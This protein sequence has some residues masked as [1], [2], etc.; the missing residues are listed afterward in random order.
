MQSHRTHLEK[1]APPLSRGFP[2]KQGKGYQPGQPH[3]EGDACCRRCGAGETLESVAPTRKNE[4]RVGQ[5]A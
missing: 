5:P 3:P 2:R 4:T 1:E